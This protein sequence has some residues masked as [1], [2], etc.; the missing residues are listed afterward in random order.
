MFD[1][2]RPPNRTAFLKVATYFQFCLVAIAY[3]IGWF[4]GINPLGSLGPN[5]QTLYWGMVG[6]IPL[7]LLFLASYRLPLAKLHD[8]KR[9]LIDRLGPYLD[10]CG[11]FDL[12]YLGLLAGFT[13]ETLFRGLLQPL[14]EEYWGWSAGLVVS[15]LLFALAHF[16]TPLYALLA[17]L[18]G[19]YLG[20]ALDFGGE[21]NLFTPMFIHAIYDFL[22]FL[23]VV[24]TY[25]GERG[26][27]F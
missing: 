3:F 26:K 27:V 15:N 24:K 21:R 20:L 13:E 16:V 25:R 18:T 1:P 4:A 6:T 23:V 5:F 10:A 12:L 7:Y 14:L 17:G 2:S 19:L 22:A 9:F 11:K 8:I